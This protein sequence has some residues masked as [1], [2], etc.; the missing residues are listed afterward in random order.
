LLC[1]LVLSTIAIF[2]KLIV[3]FVSPFLL[4]SIRIGLVCLFILVYLFS[5]GR[6]DELRVG[7]RGLM[8]YVPVGFFGV[9][10]GFGFYLKALD[11]IPV[12]NAI[13]LMY[14]YPVVTALLAARFLKE[15]L[16]SYAVLSLI[17]CV[18]G[19]WMIYGSGASFIVDFWGSMFALA[20]GIG[21]S[22]FVLSMKYMDIKGYSLWNT[23]FW[24]LLIGLIFLLPFSLLAEPVKAYMI[25]PVPYWLVGIGLVTF[26]GY[27]LY[28]KGLESI[29]AHN[30]PIIVTLTEPA[31]AVLLAFVLLGEAVP[32]YILLGGLLIIVAN[33][34][35]QLEERKTKISKRA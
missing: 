16:G 25:Y 27:Y 13:F 4:T 14:I 22:V 8:V 2:T 23:I 1:G 26:L 12:A 32:E 31:A 18:S 3:P 19:V 24:P 33:V 34:F 6:L 28:A 7:R 9:L 21:Y 35:V 30:G 5:T 20:A 10:I 15:K 11:I 17:L 29:R